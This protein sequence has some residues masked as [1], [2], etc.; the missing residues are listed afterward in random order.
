MQIL[1]IIPIYTL[2]DAS[3]SFHLQVVSLNHRF[4]FHNPFFCQSPVAC[5]LTEKIGV[6]EE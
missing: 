1:I 6:N 5:C 4:G 2:S 3:P